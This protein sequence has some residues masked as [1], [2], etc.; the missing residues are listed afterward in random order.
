MIDVTKDRGSYIG[1]SDANR[2]MKGDWLALYNE[3]MG[4]AE[5]EDLS[6]IFRVQLGIYT[7]PFHLDW[8]C[9]QHGF[10]MNEAVSYYRT[11][12]DFPCRA[13]PDR[14]VIVN[15]KEY[16]VEVK[17]TN[18]FATLEKQ[19]EWYAPQLHLQMYATQTSKCLFSF[20]AGNNDPQV[21]WI[22][23]DEE[24][25][26][27][28]L[29]VCAHFWWHIENEYPPESQLAPAPKAQVTDR[30]PYD[31]TETKSANQWADAALTMRDNEE[32]AA[33]H[34]EAKETLK[35]LV[36]DD[37]SRATGN[38]VTITVAKNGSKRFT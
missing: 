8:I 28:L 21:E 17:H 36:P 4:I 6:Q 1:A 7:E 35:E 13:N 37:A 9:Q 22:K 18:Q 10:E 3:K 33:K 20:I 26:K 12:Y 25:M 11:D 30:K 14:M 34:A 23:A 5:P 15:D 2:I 19:M 31:M 38:G 27:M 32:A 29:R 24:Y 16:P